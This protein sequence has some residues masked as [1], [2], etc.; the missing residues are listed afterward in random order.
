MAR[1]KKSGNEPS[2]LER[3]E[4]AFW[5]MLSEM[6]YESITISSLAH[7]ANVNHNTIYYYYECIDQMAL[8]LFD[9]T[10]PKNIGSLF[11]SV[12]HSGPSMFREVLS[13]EKTFEQWRKIHLFLRSDSPFL[14]DHLKK[15]L[16]ES[17]CQAMNIRPDNLTQDQRLE[18]EFIFSGMSAALRYA[19]DMNEP[20]RITV[21]VERPLG[22][23]IIETLAALQNNAE[24]DKM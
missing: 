4:A 12:I 17:W 8:D 14:I 18:L 11:L 20:S 15:R 5:E 3:M 19:F 1:P 9:K 21:L 10:L 2:A 24:T 23:A 22:R 16:I 7:R 13:D 6:P